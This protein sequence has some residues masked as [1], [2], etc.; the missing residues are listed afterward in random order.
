MGNPL[1]KVNIRVYKRGFTGTILIWNTHPLTDEQRKSR[2]VYVRLSE[3]ED[4]FIPKL[5]MPDIP[6]MGR[7]LE[8]KNDTVMILHDERID[9]KTGFELRLI[10]GDGESGYFEA[11]MRVEPSNTHKAH[12]KPERIVKADGKVVYAENANVVAMDDSV[13][14]RIA[15]AVKTEIDKGGVV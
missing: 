14:Q 1:D 6:R 3:T 10:F 11:K 7:A 5:G 2:T 4:W 15:K 13:V 8:E 9:A 12:T